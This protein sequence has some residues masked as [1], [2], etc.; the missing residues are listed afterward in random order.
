MSAADIIAAARKVREHWRAQDGINGAIIDELCDAVDSIGSSEICALP[1]SDL[2]GDTREALRAALASGQLVIVAAASLEASCAC[3][4]KE[5]MSGHRL[6]CAVVSMLTDSATEETLRA[7]A[8]SV[9]RALQLRAR[10][11]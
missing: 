1:A 11:P 9:V 8:K 10:A 6:D 5:R 3:G 4:V 7:L 2:F